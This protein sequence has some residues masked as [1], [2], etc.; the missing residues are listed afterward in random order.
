MK[1]RTDCAAF[2][3]ALALAGFGWSTALADD[4]PDDAERCIQ[5]IRLDSIDIL[6]DRHILFN[7]RGHDI[8]LNELPRSCPGLRRDST[9]MY[10]TSLDKLCDIDVITILEPL[11]GG[12]R[13]TSSC[14]LGK[15]HPISKER[16]EELRK[17]S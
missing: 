2:L 4:P 16:A 11:G 5:L 14:G 13:P 6:N 3:A 15:F 12:L 7:M 17:A 9:I 1:Y 10:R 8:Y